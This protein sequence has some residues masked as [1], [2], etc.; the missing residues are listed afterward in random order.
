M[1]FH[2]SYTR[3][4]FRRV[5][6]LITSLVENGLVSHWKMES[7]FELHRFSWDFSIHI[8]D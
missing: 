8:Q 3:F 1:E 4:H 6:L 2:E 5:R 7:S